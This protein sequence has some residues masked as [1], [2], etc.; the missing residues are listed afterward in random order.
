MPAH[1]TYDPNNLS[2]PWNTNISISFSVSREVAAK[3]ILHTHISSWYFLLI[4]ATCEANVSSSFKYQVTQI[5][6][7]AAINTFFV[8]WFVYCPVLRFCW[9]WIPFLFLLSHSRAMFC[10]AMLKALAFFLPVFFPLCLFLHYMPNFTV[11]QQ[12]QL[13]FCKYIDLIYIN[14]C[15][16]TTFRL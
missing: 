6:P 15:L 10:L 2:N 3:K 14:H 12:F 7:T 5:S 16:V 8:N 11:L 1:S 13:K 4:H 9:L